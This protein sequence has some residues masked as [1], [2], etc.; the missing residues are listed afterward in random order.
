MKLTQIHLSNFQS[1]GPESTLI[2]MAEMTFVLGPNGT[3]KTAVLQ[4][5]VRLF[6]MDPS[7]RRIR[8]TDFHV[9]AGAPAGAH[10][11]ATL[12][13]EAQFEFP[14]LTEKTKGKHPSVP[15]HFAHMRLES[16]DGVPRVRFRL[17]AQMDDDGEIEE[18]MVYVL[19]VDAEGKP[20]K[21]AVASKNDHSSIQVHYLPA[22][23]DPSDHVSYA[24]NSL[25]GRALRAADWRAEREAVTGLTEAIGR[26]LAGNAAIQGVGAKLTT[27]WGSL[28]KGAYYANPSLSFERSE[29][30]NL[31]RHLTVS[32][33]PGHAEPL[34]DF[35]RLSDGQQ[36]LLYLS[37]VLSM[38]SIGRE[39]LANK[40]PAFDIDK[41]RPAVFTL[42]AMEE[43]ENSLSPHYLGRVIKALTTF[44]KEHDSQAIVA[45]HAPSL[46]RRGDL[47]P[48]RERKAAASPELEG[49]RRR[50]AHHGT[51]VESRAR[52]D[53]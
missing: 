15:G 6:G 46:L 31:L 17:S 9:A 22:R 7:L 35:S 13:I 5:L 39:V 1:F 27:H 24:A 26:A 20:S 36:S 53:E 30:D 28:H 51:A 47:H 42:I 43:P 14:E 4:A 2:D 12:W 48:G 32:F 50:Y 34:V 38:Q 52:T 33:T 40:L 16:A 29:I 49:G 37:L 3:G 18:S 45:T 19:Q 8:K 10:A 41:L 25:L 11:A 44:S 23:R 21:S